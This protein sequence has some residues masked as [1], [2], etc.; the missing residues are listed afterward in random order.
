MTSTTI[1]IDRW[2][3]MLHPAALDAMAAELDALAEVNRCART[4]REAVAQLWTEHDEQVAASRAAAD[5]GEVVELPPKP[6]PPTDDFDRQIGAATAAVGTK[7]YANATTITAAMVDDVETM[8]APTRRALRSVLEGV[9]PTKNDVGRKF[10]V[11]RLNAAITTARL[12]ATQPP[13]P[14]LGALI[15]PAQFTEAEL[16]AIVIEGRGARQILGVG[17][18]APVNALLR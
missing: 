1:G 4:F 10:D 9:L 12:L 13:A 5:G 2:P 16:L 17:T 3:N 7:F 18:T 6:T 11:A 8:I 14:G 15:E